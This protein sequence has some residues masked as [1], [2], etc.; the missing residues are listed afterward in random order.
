MKEAVPVV[1]IVKTSK[2][3]DPPIVFEIT[4]F[5]DPGA[6]VKSR[7]VSSLLIVLENVITSFEEVNVTSALKVTAPVYV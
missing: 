3:A 2:F 5:P 6:K 1:L 7:A 4:I